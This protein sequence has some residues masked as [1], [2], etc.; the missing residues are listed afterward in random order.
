MAL[1]NGL[2]ALD[3]ER[4]S[5]MNFGVPSKWYEISWVVV[6]LLASRERYH[7]GGSWFFS[8]SVS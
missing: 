2:G 6:C 8:L 4:D 3:Q 5:K 7:F 1:G